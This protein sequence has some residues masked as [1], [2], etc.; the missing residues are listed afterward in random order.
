MI[1]RTCFERPIIIVSSSMEKIEQHVVTVSEYLES[2]ELII[3]LFQ[4][5]FLSYTWSLYFH[6]RSKTR[7]YDLD[8]QFARKSRVLFYIAVSRRFWYDSST[9]W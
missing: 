4:S 6:T 8:S 9:A 3:R 1:C 5:A 2:C 7:T